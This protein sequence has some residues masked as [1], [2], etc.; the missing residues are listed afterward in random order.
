MAGN[1]RFFLV[2]F[3][4]LSTRESVRNIVFS[5]WLSAVSLRACAVC[6]NSVT[7]CGVGSRQQF[8]LELMLLLGLMKLYLSLFIDIVVLSETRAAKCFVFVSSDMSLNVE[9]ENCDY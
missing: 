7:T 6:Q 9:L 5:G 3:H 4:F 8:D 1:P 2:L